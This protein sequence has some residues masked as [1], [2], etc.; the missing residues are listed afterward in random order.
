VN[1]IFN[2]EYVRHCLSAGFHPDLLWELTEVIQISLL[3]LG[4]GPSGQKRDTKGRGGEAKE[5]EEEAVKG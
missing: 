2:S 5:T 1:L 3:D 4:R